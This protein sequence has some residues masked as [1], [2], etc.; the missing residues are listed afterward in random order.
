MEHC[1]GCRLAIPGG[2]AGCQMIFDRLLEREFSD[3]R[4]FRVHRMNVDSYSLQHPD[5][6][7][8]SAKSF[9][10][11]LCG[12]C[13]AMEFDSDPGM[14]KALRTS[15]DGKIELQKPQLPE[16][17]GA[18]TVAGLEGIEDVHAY[19]QAAQRWAKDVW[20]AYAPLHDLAHEWLR[21]AK[22]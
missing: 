15:L 18:L 4:Y 6:Y 17:R 22:K 20:E 13:C 5:E 7:C 9:M 11:H 1:P 10:A 3:Y 12:M 8:A 16:S 14:L 19:A 2:R 21:K